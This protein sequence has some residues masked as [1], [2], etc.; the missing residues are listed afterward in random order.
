MTH[1][2][3]TPTDIIKSLKDLFRINFTLEEKKKPQ[4]NKHIRI[5][6]VWQSFIFQFIVSRINIIP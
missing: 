6:V 5:P 3:R 4:I 1:S 2:E